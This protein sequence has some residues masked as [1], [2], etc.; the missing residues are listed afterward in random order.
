M[1]DLAGAYV[2]LVWHTD[3]NG[4]RVPPGGVIQLTH[5][6]AVLSLEQK[7]A[8]PVEMAPASHTNHTPHDEETHDG[9]HE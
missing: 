3:A 6:E 4:N 2:A 8:K 5:D 9:E 1:S 7:L